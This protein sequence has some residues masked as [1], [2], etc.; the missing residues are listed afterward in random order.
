MPLIR[1]HCIHRYFCVVL[2]AIVNSS[3]Y[4]TYIVL[5]NEHTI[6]SSRITSNPKLSPFFNPSL[7]TIDC[8]HIRARVPAADAARYRDRDGNLTFNHLAAC[9]S[10][11]YFLYVLPGWEGSAGDGRVYL[12]ARM[13]DFSIPPMR[14][15]LADAGFS[16]CNAL[17]VPYRN[18]CYHLHEYLRGSQR[19]ELLTLR[20]NCHHLTSVR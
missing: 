16:S 11:M 17:L 1:A 2:D 7:G 4:G 19:Y 14:F 15:Y 3:F 18:V 5:P 9:S 12:D 20:E 8:T 13:N 6:L 10:D